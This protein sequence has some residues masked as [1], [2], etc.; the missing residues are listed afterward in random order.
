MDN[1]PYFDLQMCKADL[2]IDGPTRICFGLIRPVLFRVNGTRLRSVRGRLW[3]EGGPAKALSGA[4]P[5]A[6]FDASHDHEVSLHA[7]PVLQ[8][9]LKSQA[10]LQISELEFKM[11][12]SVGRGKSS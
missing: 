3:R 5:C 1:C 6:A 2:G 9:C 4:L 12:I 8:T 7:T 11:H 10:D